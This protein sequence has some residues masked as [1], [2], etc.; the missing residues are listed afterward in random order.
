MSNRSSR[1]AL[2]SG[3]R[4]IM[5]AATVP[6]TTR[7]PPPS[8]L[9]SSGVRLPYPV[10]VSN[11]THATQPTAHPA[12]GQGQ[13]NGPAAKPLS[14]GRHAKPYVAPVVASAGMRDGRG[15]ERAGASAAPTNDTGNVARSEVR[16]PL[17]A[18]VVLPV[19]PQIDSQ[20][21]QYRDIGP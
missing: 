5:D 4:N 6:N 10:T 12:P 1:T 11:S 19:L 16:G 7:S 8:W 18:P 13:G 3:V 21:W 17:A 2:T 9:L 14:G 15:A 20:Y